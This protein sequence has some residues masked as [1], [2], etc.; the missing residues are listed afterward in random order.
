MDLEV[1]NKLKCGSGYDCK[2]RIVM[3]A[4]DE[5]VEGWMDVRKRKRDVG[6]E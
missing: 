6:G 3:V 1:W 5:L 2:S 4:R